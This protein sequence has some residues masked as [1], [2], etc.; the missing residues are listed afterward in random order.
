MRIVRMMI[1][2]MLMIP[3]SI[4][5]AITPIVVTVDTGVKTTIPQIIEGL[6]D[7]LLRWSGFI[8]TG[9]FLLGAIMMVGSGGEDSILSAGKRIMKATAI[10]LFLVLISWMLLSTAV[11]FFSV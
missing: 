4:F 9:L 7:V 10:G 11:Y 1:G 3:T 6:Q 8:A 2:M 5:A